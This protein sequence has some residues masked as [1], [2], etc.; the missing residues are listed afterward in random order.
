[1]NGESSVLADIDGAGTKNGAGKHG[2]ASRRDEESKTV[3]TANAEM[4][5]SLPSKLGRTPHAREP[6]TDLVT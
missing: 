5:L 1:M 3:T 2:S 4:G 6:R